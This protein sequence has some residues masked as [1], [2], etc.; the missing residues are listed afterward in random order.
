M[1]SV[2]PAHQVVP[3]IAG[4]GPPVAEAGGGVLSDRGRL[5]AKDRRQDHEDEQRGEE[6]QERRPDDREHE[7]T[8]LLHRPVET[9]DRRNLLRARNGVG[10]IAHLAFNTAA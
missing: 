7:T 4:L 8:V 9:P 6:R 10:A 5:R 3:T 2:R 1:W